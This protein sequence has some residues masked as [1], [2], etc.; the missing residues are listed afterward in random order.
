MAQLIKTIQNFAFANELWEKNSKIIIAVSGGSDS[1]C[2]LDVF[3]K[4]APKYDL[5][6][7]IAHVNY[8]LRGKESEKDEIFV[9]E[10]AKKY[11]VPVTVFKPK[12]S[13]YKGNLENSLREIRYAFFEKLR[14]ELKFDLVAIAH[15]QDDQAETVLMRIMRGSGLAGLSAMKPKT[16]RVIRPLLQ[17]SKK[18]ILAYLKEN[19]LKFQTD[20]TNLDTKFTRNNVRHKL[21]PYLEKNFNPAIKKTLSEWSFSV[22][23]DYA[24]IERSAQ[25]FV[26]SVCKNKCAHFSAK[27]FLLQDPALARQALRSIASKFKENTLDLESGQIEEM[28]KMIKS[29]KSKSQ[30]ATIGGLNISKKGDKVDIRC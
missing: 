5:E 21:L 27:E 7:H 4:L 19:K 16:N 2:L 6:L 17:T 8:A 15:N 30:K 22:A 24:F 18:E 3:S 11:D 9:R 14:Q 26:E 28:L 12:K 13:E 10:L 20:K 29:T 25:F 1:S 23:D